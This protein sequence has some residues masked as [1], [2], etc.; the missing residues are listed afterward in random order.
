MVIYALFHT[1]LWVKRDISKSSISKQ[2][3]KAAKTTLI[4]MLTCTI[5]WLPAVFTHLLICL[6]GCQYQ[7]QNFSPHTLFIISSISYSL[8]ILKSFSNPMIFAM[9]QQNIREALKRLLHYIRYCQDTDYRIQNM[10]YNSVMLSTMD[11]FPQHQSRP[12]LRKFAVLHEFRRADTK[13]SLL[14][15]TTA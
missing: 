13:T 15:N 7:L 9:R 11:K 3:I 5:G 4:I 2:N 6:E 14:T 8:L 1:L 10:G 12:D